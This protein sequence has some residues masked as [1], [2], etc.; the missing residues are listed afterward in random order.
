MA[1]IYD[2]PY[3]QQ[4]VETFVPLPLQEI[5]DLG[6]QLHQ[7]RIA[8][9]SSMS[10]VEKA[11]ANMN[12]ANSVYSAGDVNDPGYKYRSTGYAELQAKVLHDLSTKHKDLTDKYLSGAIDNDQFSNEA[13]KFQSQFAAD[14]AKLRNAEQ[15][16]KTIFEVNKKISESAE[17]AQNPYLLN[18]HAQEGSNLLQDPYNNQYHAVPIGKGLKESEEVNTWAK[19]IKPTLISVDSGKTDSHGNT[20]YSQVKGVTPERIDAL[21][22]QLDQSDIGN[23]WRE[24]TRFELNHIGKRLGDKINVDVP[25]YDKSNKLTGY[26]TEEVDAFN[27][28]YNQKKTDF[29]N[30]VK[31]KAVYKDLDTKVVQDWKQRDDREAARKKAEEGIKTLAGEAIPHQGIITL[32]TLPQEISDFVDVNTDGTLSYN[33]NKSQSDNLNFSQFGVEYGLK[34]LPETINT[35]KIDFENKINEMAQSLGIPSK[36][37][38]FKKEDYNY[39]I[40][41]FNEKSKVFVQ[42]HKFHNTIQEALKNDFINYPNSYNIVDDKNQPLTEDVKKELLSTP[43]NKIHLTNNTIG[44]IDK[45]NKNFIEGSYLNPEGNLVTFKLR[46]L[47]LGYNNTF[48]AVAKFKNESLQIAINPSNTGKIIKQKLPEL[49]KLNKSSDN[50]KNTIA[51]TLYNSTNGLSGN[52]QL[53]KLQKDVKANSIKNTVNRFAITNFQQIGNNTYYTVAVPKPDKKVKNVLMSNV[54]IKDYDYILFRRDNNGI[55]HESGDIS[56]VDNI[57]IDDYFLNTDQGQGKIQALQTNTK[58]AKDYLP[59]Q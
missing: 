11:V 28:L 35:K 14:F 4:Y 56:N 50:I 10:D 38:G 9:E 32:R 59:K 29:I 36:P 5:G 30:A 21:A 17:A 23:Q 20:I 19:D 22:E 31:T 51:E 24:Q 27:F 15:N 57:A 8:D 6:K 18:A 41:T 42:D 12:L 40:N 47:D 34:A 7:Q 52:E 16:S 53:T 39:I 54:D 44:E 37:G 26:K 43:E 33:E 58:Q 55:M 46:P 45:E 2:K 3:G 13:R 1:N 25:Q 48:D 49:E